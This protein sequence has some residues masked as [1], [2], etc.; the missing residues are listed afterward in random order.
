MDF[1]NTTADTLHSASERLQQV[2][3]LDCFVQLLL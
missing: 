1:S 2:K 3:G